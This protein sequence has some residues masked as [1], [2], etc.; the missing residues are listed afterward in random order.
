MLLGLYLSIYATP[1]IFDT[2]VILE[3]V[4][5]TSAIFGV[6]AISAILVCVLACVR[7]IHDIGH[8]VVSV[9]NCN[10]WCG[11][12]IYHSG[13]LAISVILVCWPYQSFGVLAIY[14]PFG[15][16]A[17]YQPFGVVAL[18]QSF[19][20]VGHIGYFGVLAL[21]AIFS[22]FGVLVISA[23]LVCQPFWCVGHFGHSGVMVILAILMC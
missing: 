1:V 23:M 21:S 13:V 2:S 9:L 3:N 11:C 14:Q 18:Y 15:V 8:F 4:F 5:A 16:L 19:W 22:V 7:N 10:F 12:Y 6:F 20:C 17:I